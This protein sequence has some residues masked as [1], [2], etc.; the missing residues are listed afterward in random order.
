MNI[1]KYIKK[2]YTFQLRKRE[3]VQGYLFEKP[4]GRC[5]P[6]TTEKLM[7]KTGFTNR[8]WSQRDWR[9]TALRHRVAQRYGVSSS[10]GA[11]CHIRGC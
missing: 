10:C 1:L 5:H 9:M 3:R 11:R 7:N 6:N 2:D 4:S 8:Y